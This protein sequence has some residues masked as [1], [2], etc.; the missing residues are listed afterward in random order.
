VPSK[1]GRN[2]LIH[3]A[4]Q[5]ACLS[6]ETCEH[7]TL[8]GWQPQKMPRRHKIIMR[9]VVPM[10]ANV[11]ANVIREVVSTLPCWRWLL[12]FA[13][14]SALNVRDLVVNV[15]YLR[16]PPAPKEVATMD[17]A[18]NLFVSVWLAF[19]AVQWRSPILL[20]L[21]VFFDELRVP[22]ICEH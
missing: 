6:R 7:Q 3:D 2:D 18:A 20:Q 21:F 22:F 4:S 5:L 1:G 17:V 14:Q 12:M 16:C 11:A 13:F 9:R 8:N 10:A 19:D 15:A